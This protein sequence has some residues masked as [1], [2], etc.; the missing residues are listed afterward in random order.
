MTPLVSLQG[1]LWNKQY[2]IHTC[3]QLRLKLFLFTCIHICKL[4]CTSIQV[5]LCIQTLVLCFQLCCSEVSIDLLLFMAN[6][7]LYSWTKVFPHL[8]TFRCYHAAMILPA[9]G[10]PPLL[11]AFP[12][13][14]RLH[15]VQQKVL[16][17]THNKR[18]SHDNG[19]H[20][21]V[22]MQF[23]HRP[24]WSVHSTDDGSLKLPVPLEL[25]AAIATW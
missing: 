11:L 8:Q 25:V 24:V 1:G 23:I 18:T 6:F 14:L 12:G 15:P 16:Q 9:T 4:M 13:Q 20:R 17:E 21:A 2:N 10:L 3:T 7:M 19:L 22:T 5:E